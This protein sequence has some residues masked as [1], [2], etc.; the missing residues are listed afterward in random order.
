MEAV[1]PGMKAPL[2]RRQFG[3]QLL[4]GSALALANRGTSA[5]ADATAKKGPEDHWQLFAGELQTGLSLDR[6]NAPFASC[7]GSDHRE[8]DLQ[9]QP[10]RDLSRVSACPA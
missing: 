4:A 7:F 8:S 9:Y 5:S 1:I 2:N 10:T 6:G 3:K